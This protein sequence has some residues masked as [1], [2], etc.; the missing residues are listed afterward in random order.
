M[1]GHRVRTP[2][3]SPAAPTWGAS[4][5]ERRED[6]L[7][8][9]PERRLFLIRHGRTLLNAEGRFRGRQDAPLDEQGWIDAA[10]AGAAAAVSHEV[11]IRLVL[12][13]CELDPGAA[14][15]A[16]LPPGSV[17]GLIVGRRGIRLERATG[18]LIDP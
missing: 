11:P 10:H 3:G 8:A 9:F 14:W 6:R 1:D 13:Q 15:G 5:R 12:A 18:A 17:I 2:K 7:S 4:E 16:L